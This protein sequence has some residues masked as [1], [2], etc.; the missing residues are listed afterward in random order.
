MQLQVSGS[1][2]STSINVIDSAQ[3]HTSEQES[4]YRRLINKLLNEIFIL[5]HD[6][7]R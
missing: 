5:D 2:D 3:L 7:L 1:P 6:D 4:R